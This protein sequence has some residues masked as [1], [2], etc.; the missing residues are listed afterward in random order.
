MKLF[1]PFTIPQKDNCDFCRGKSNKR[2]E[3]ENLRL[4]QLLK[5]LF[6]SIKKSPFR[7]DREETFFN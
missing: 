3:V 1:T 4:D 5:F 7:N 2:R 6:K